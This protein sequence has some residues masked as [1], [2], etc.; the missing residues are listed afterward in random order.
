LFGLK[1]TQLWNVLCFQKPIY[2]NIYSLIC[3]H[4]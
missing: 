2:K 3:N 4:W 1:L